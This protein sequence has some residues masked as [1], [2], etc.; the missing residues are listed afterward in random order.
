MFIITHLVLG[1]ILGKLFGSYSFALIGALIPDIDHIFPYIRH[2]ILFHM[3]KLWKTITASKDKYHDQ[4][5]YLHSLFIVIPVTII[6]LVLNYSLFLVFSLAYLSHLFL[7][8]LDNS[9]FYP[10]YPIKKKIL[11]PIKYFSKTEFIITFGL[12][13][14]YLVI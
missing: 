4:R 1:L 11:G 2:K 14:V 13:I 3:K 9:E 5:N 10:F 6:M 8:S 7:D 12:F